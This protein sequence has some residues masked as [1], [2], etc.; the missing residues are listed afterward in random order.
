MTLYEIKYQTNQQ[1][2]VA[3]IENKLK[4]VVIQNYHIKY[5][6][7]INNFNKINSMLKK[8]IALNA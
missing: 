3:K 5:N 7:H 4:I 6:C 1:K 8:K 2:Y